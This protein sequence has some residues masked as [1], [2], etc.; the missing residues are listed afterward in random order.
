MGL[1]RR[2]IGDLYERR[3]VGYRNA[4]AMVTGS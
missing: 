3:Y 2:E 4:L 1:R